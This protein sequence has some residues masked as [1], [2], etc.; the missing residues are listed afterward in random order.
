MTADERIHVAWMKGQLR[1][2]PA[3]YLDLL[4]EM[5]GER[6]TP[7]KAA[8]AEE[9]YLLDLVTRLPDETGKGD[10]RYLNRGRHDTNAVALLYWC[11]VLERKIEGLE[12][13]LEQ[14]T[15]FAKTA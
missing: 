2:T 15:V 3:R 6:M 1:Q 7:E 11:R 12:A 9:L 8:M 14:K 5:G 4:A 10:V 13:L